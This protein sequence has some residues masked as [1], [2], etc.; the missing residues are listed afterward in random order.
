VI[1]LLALLWLVRTLLEHRRWNRTFG[2][3]TEIYNKLLE[4]FAS[5]EELIAYVQSEAGKRFLASATLPQV[6]ETRG[7]SAVSRVLTPL[8]IGS[9]MTL[10]GFGFL[11]LKH[12]VGESI[13]LL[14]LGT[15]AVALGLGFMISAGL[16]WVMARRLGIMGQAGGQNDGS[17]HHEPGL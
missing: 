2:V 13:P 9:V 16:A 11:Y 3:Q 15:L 17:I 5:N 1:V 7:T 6:P 12:D 10:A 14:G 8:Q 4:K